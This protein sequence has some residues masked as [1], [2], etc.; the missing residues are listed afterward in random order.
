[1]RDYLSEICE[2]NLKSLLLNQAQERKVDGLLIQLDEPN[3]VTLLLQSENLTVRGAL[4][5]FESDLEAYPMLTSRVMS[6]AR[7]VNNLQFEADFLK[8][9]NKQAD[10]LSETEKFAVHSLLLEPQS[11]LAKSVRLDSI[12]ERALENIRCQND[13]ES[14]Y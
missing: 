7:I 14:W 10:T 6:D 4:A 3:E 9:Q 13:M 5:Y 11:E 8:L 12:V 1:M 2:D